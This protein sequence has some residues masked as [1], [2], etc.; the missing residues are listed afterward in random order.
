M[1]VRLAAVGDLL[2]AADPGRPAAGEPQAIFDAVRPALSEAD[3]VFANLE[4]T[5]P[6]DGGTVATEPRVVSTPEWVRSIGTAGVRVVSLANNHMFDHLAEGFRNVRCLLGEMG[7]AYFGAGD[8]LV[9]ATAPAILEVRGV[10]LAFVGGADERSG[11]RRFAESNQW[12]VAPIDIR[13]LVDQ[14]RHLRTEVDHVIVSLHWGEERLPI[15]SPEQVEQSHALVEAGASLILGHHSHVVQGLEVYHG[16]PIIYSLG[17]FVAR[18]VPYA[19]GDRLTWN[20]AERTGCILRCDLVAHEARNVSQVP[21]YYDGARI[22]IDR[23]GFGDR[24]VARANRALAQGVTLAR[25]RRAFFWAKTVL[26]TVSHL[27]WSEL[28]RLRPSK[29]RKALAGIVSARRAR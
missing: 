11:T 18:E 12:G 17:N 22:Q 3:V 7:I 26:P 29:I 14:I 27:R 4:C 16:A 9:E 19:N 23:S 10:R 5:L 2:L 28:K 24:V 15:P 13:R 1:P 25:Y 6:G 21:T 20:R 8:R